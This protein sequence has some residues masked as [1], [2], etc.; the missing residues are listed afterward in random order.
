[1]KFERRGTFGVGASLVLLFVVPASANEPGVAR[2]V[3]A[4]TAASDA[5]VLAD[6]EQLGDLEYARMRDNIDKKTPDLQKKFKSYC[7]YDVNVVIDWPSFGRG[8]DTLSNLWSNYGVERLVD[9]FESVCRDQLGKDAAKAKI[10]TIKA[11]N[12]KD[13][14]SIKIEVGGAAMTATLTWGATSPGLNESEIG[15]RITKQL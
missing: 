5:L 10:K 15:A 14:K 1:M 7:G 12:T 2:T 4:P 11:I 6:E 13:P 8:K 9:S 3:S